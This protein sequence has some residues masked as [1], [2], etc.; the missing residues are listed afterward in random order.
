MYI[1]MYTHVYGRYKSPS[2]RKA[3]VCDRL[4][5][6]ILGLDPAGGHVSLSIVGVALKAKGLS[7]RP[8]RR[9]QSPTECSE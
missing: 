6:A 3:R 9:L 4:L 5:A 8:I 7:D 1:Y 2:N